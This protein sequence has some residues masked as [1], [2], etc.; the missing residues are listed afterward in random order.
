MNVMN[1]FCG[2]IRCSYL[3]PVT[4][5]GDI[6]HPVHRYL[7]NILGGFTVGTWWIQCALVRY[8]LGGEYDSYCYGT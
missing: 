4:F 5:F 2:C 3:L 1:I 6:K 7:M 8:T